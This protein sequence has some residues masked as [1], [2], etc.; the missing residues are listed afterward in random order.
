MAL[1]LLDNTGG[2]SQM[3]NSSNSQ[4]NDSEGYNFLKD[5]MSVRQDSIGSPTRSPTQI[6]ISDTYPISSESNSLEEEIKEDDNDD[7]ARRD[8]LI[9][10]RKEL[11]DKDSNMHEEEGANFTALRR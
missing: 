8:K 7:L 4:F 2:Y 11:W 6:S 10:H 1:L 9:H 3:L 5:L